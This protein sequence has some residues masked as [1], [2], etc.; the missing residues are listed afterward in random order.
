MQELLTAAVKLF[1]K[2]PP[3][4][5]PALK[6]ILGAALVDSN[7]IVSERAS[8]YCQILSQHGREKMRHII[9][10][11]MEGVTR[12]GGKDVG[13]SDEL[14]D[15][16]FD[17]W[18]SLSVVY[19]A[20]AIT[21][22]DSDVGAIR[23]LESGSIGGDI[24]DEILMDNSNEDQNISLLDFAEEDAGGFDGAA[25]LADTDA[26]DTIASTH[27]NSNSEKD[28]NE[29][30]ALSGVTEERTIRRPQQQQELGDLIDSSG[31]LDHASEGNVATSAASFELTNPL[32]FQL[33]KQEY[34]SL[35]SDLEIY[36]TVVKHPLSSESIVEAI[37]AE[38]FRTF[39]SH[40]GQAN[41]ACLD[42][43]SANSQQPYHY[44]FYAKDSNT[45]S[46]LLLDVLLSASEAKVDIRSENLDLQEYI[47]GILETLLMTFV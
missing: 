38:D 2:R 44:R 8:I 18:N 28:L 9:E 4:S 12:T 41:L 29:L 10:P 19:S 25:K 46:I 32:S 24:A 1:C 11:K 5:L 16:L 43:P 20:P 23:R 17:E 22:L 13:I 3:E 39:A 42:M 47:K 15:K 45:G 33:I 26:F 7:Y 30:M 14:G 6:S 36:S 37:K 31:A 35:W 40:I 21:F 34:E 27:A